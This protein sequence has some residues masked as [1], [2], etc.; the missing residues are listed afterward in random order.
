[1]KKS[2]SGT[3]LIHENPLTYCPKIICSLS[4]RVTLTSG[5]GEP[6]PSLFYDSTIQC[7]SLSS[8]AQK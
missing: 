3:T 1:M 7:G 5:D 8:I 2:G 4:R 6:L